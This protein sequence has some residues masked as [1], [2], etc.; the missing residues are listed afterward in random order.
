MSGKLSHKISVDVNK[1]LRFKV[2]FSIIYI[3]RNW[4][5]ITCSTKE[6]LLCYTHLI[7]YF[8]GI[9]IMSQFLKELMFK[10]F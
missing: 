7:D 6:E 1:D 5:Q 2:N 9:K 10:S 3:V 8:A 4:E